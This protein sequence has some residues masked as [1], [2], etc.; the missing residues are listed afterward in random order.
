MGKDIPL[1]HHA[2][3]DDDEAAGTQ[4]VEASRT[5]FDS[6]VEH[7]LPRVPAVND[8]D[9]LAELLAGTGPLLLD[10]DGPVC[11]VF[12]GYPAPQIAAQLGR[13][14][15]DNGIDVS[16]AVAMRTRSVESPALDR[17][18]RQAGPDPNR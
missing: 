13:L 3:T 8:R 4:F 14:L 12:A 10:F 7:H 9:R 16:E 18:A 2:V 5:W 6:R 17:P 15:Q 1:F 11:S